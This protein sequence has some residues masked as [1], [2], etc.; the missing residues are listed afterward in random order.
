[1]NLSVN[2]TAHKPTYEKENKI[3]QRRETVDPG[4]INRDNSR[5]GLQQSNS[6]KHFE[7]LINRIPE[8]E[9][10]NN[11]NKQNLNTED[12]NIKTA[13]NNSNS[14]IK[15]KDVRETNN[16]DLTIKKSKDEKD[17]YSLSIIN[18]TRS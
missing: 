3:I 7:G 16:N 17:K 15:T 8:V 13:R 1:M 14:A 11:T 5:T 12:S 6:D 4:V 2:N 9:S 18:S 10:K